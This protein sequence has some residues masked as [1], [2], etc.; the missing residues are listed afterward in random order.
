MSRNECSNRASASDV[1]ADR[2]AGG[3]RGGAHPEAVGA[4]AVALSG[5]AA[6]QPDELA[7]LLDDVRRIAD[8]IGGIQQL[9]V[10]VSA[11]RTVD[12]G[13][14]PTPSESS[15]VASLRA[16]LESARA[17]NDTHARVPRGLLRDAIWRLED[18]TGAK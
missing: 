2:A 8:G 4:R 3:D 13:D 15:V 11:R 16:C 12:V 17:V 18:L 9:A 10:T 6:E 1:C 14:H 7:Q 5:A